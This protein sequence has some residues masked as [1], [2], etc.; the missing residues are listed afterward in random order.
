MISNWTPNTI[1]V[2]QFTLGNG[3]VN[4]QGQGRIC[5]Q[6]STQLQ[7]SDLLDITFPNTISLVYLNSITDEFF[8]LSTLAF[9]YNTGQY[10]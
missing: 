3:V 10:S 7:S 9:V 1:T 8:V 5:F 2:Q 4:V 6:T